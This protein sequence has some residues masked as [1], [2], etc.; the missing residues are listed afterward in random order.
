MP[1]SSAEKGCNVNNLPPIIPTRN[2]IFGVFSRVFIITLSIGI[3]RLQN[4]NFSPAS[5]LIPDVNT[6][7]DNF[8]SSRDG[9][10][11]LLEIKAKP[12]APV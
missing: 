6:R 10:N 11:L 8:S 4:Y 12:G 7:G 5:Y 2:I 1:N 3:G 9:Q